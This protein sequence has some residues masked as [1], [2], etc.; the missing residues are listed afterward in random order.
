MTTRSMD[1]TF[2]GIL[3]ALHRQ[4][5]EKKCREQEMPCFIF[6]FFYFTKIFDTVSRPGLNKVLASTLFGIHFAHYTFKDDNDDAFIH[7]HLDG[8]LLNF[9]CLRVKKKTKS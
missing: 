6:F 8:S 5:S 1:F 2:T 4:L 3:T 7:T 9:A